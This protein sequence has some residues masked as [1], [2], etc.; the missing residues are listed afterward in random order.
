VNL[1]RRVFLREGLERSRQLVLVV[2]GLRLDRDVDDRLGEVEGLEDYGCIRVAEGVAGRGLLEADQRNDVASEARLAVLAVVGVHLQDAP[3]PFLAVLGRI[4]DLASRLQVARVHAR[5]GELAE[6]RVGHD[7]E[8][9]GRERLVVVR[10]AL[11][12]LHALDVHALRGGDVDRAGEVRNDRVQ[13]WLHALVLERAAAQ[14]RN[15]LAGDRGRTQRPL[16]IRRGDLLLAKELLGDRVVEVGQGVDEGVSVALGLVEQVRRDVDQ[17]ELLTLRRVVCPHHGL[18]R[19]KVDTP[20]ELALGPDWK[21]DDGHGRV[22]T[23]LD[24]VDAP[25]EIGADAVH[26]VDEAHPR[27]PVLIRL[28]PNRLGL[29]FHAGDGVE[30]SDS[31]VEDTQRPLHL[32]REVDVAGGVDDVDPVTVPFAGGGCGRDGDAALLLLRHPVHRGRALV[33]L[34]DLVVDPRVEEDP[35]R[36]RGLARV[37][38]GH[39]PDVADLGQWLRAY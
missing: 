3:D 16:E 32:D 28:S 25:E 10:L 18:H 6:M 31:A 35:L 17:V 19:E 34:T 29:G 9:E 26:L 23:V 4:D 11:E 21:L 33:D 37:D 8:G 1:E 39:D 7:L 5:V 30:Y 27:H 20:L 15:H 2:L 24:H 36:G 38:V 12:L 13:H 22:E 14:D